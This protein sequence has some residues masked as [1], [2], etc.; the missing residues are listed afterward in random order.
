MEQHFTAYKRNYTMCTIVARASDP[1]AA[2][3]AERKHEPLLSGWRE[4]ASGVTLS[5]NNKLANGWGELHNW[6]KECWER[7]VG[8]AG[9]QVTGTESCTAL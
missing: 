2:L 7:Q 3:R 4:A 8:A 6:G 9:L 1:P 5:D